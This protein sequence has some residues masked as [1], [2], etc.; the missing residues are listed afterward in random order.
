MSENH[1]KHSPLDQF[2]VENLFEIKAGGLDLSITN[3]SLYMI[4][5]TLI[6]VSFSFFSTKK[7][8]LLP[9]KFQIFVEFI[10][11]FILGIISSTIGKK[12]GEKFFPLIFSIFIFIVLCNIIGLT[13]YSFTVTSQIIVTLTV[14]L[15]CFLTLIVFSIYRN[16]FKGFISMFIP[17][18]LPIIIIPLIF[19]I[20][21][22]SFL[23]KPI[24]LSVRLFANMVAGHVLLKV[25]ATFVVSLGFF[26]FLPL[27]FSSAMIAFELFVAILQAYIFSILVCSYLAEATKSH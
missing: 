21:F 22:F 3:S 19:S 26:G 5:T 17:S 13:P 24:T 10:Y 16:G 2:K 8:D 1:E 15:L 7:L 20:E 23:V 9:K 27:L 4:I 6:V 18:G 11:N 14:A 25:V 12:E